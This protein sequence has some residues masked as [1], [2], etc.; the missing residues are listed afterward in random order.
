MKTPKVNVQSNGSKL[1]SLTNVACACDRCVL[2]IKS[3]NS[4]GRGQATRLPPG[5]MQPLS[6]GLGEK[7]P[8]ENFLSLFASEEE[9]AS[10]QIAI[11]PRNFAVRAS[12]TASSST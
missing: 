12:S 3:F 6:L 10:E 4:G 1:R 2:L 9:A 11:I 7:T 8:E 5:S